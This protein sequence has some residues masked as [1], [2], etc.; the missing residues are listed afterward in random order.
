MSFLIVSG[1]LTSEWRTNA[2]NPKRANRK[3]L[4]NAPNNFGLQKDHSG[5]HD[6]EEMQQR[7]GRIGQRRQRQRKGQ[8]QSELNFKY[9]QQI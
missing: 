4:N 1:I 7:P 3:S 6:D 9:I 2:Q 8:R 5:L